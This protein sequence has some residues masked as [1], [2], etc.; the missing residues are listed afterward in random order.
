MRFVMIL[1]SD[2]RMR[3]GKL[4]ELSKE[5]ATGELGNLTARGELL[6]ESIVYED[7]VGAFLGVI[8]IWLLTL[9]TGIYMCRATWF[10]SD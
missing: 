9:A 6:P 5:V 10:S 8:F 2:K 1:M 7:R 3:Y 4:Y